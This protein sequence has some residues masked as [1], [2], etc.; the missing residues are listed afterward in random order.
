LAI[1]KRSSEVWQVLGAVK[2]EFNKFSS[3][4]EK[5][6]KKLTEA[7]SELDLLVGTRSRMLLS[8]LKNV[9]ELPIEQSTKLLNESTD[10]EEV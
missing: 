7:N 9:E 3:V 5:T 2:T 10:I 1:Q 8:K 6:Q 4:L